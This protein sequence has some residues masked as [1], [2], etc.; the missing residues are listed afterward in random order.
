MSGGSRAATSEVRVLKASLLLF[1]LVGVALTGS[2]L[3]YFSRSEFMPYHSQAIQ[4]DWSALTPHYQGLLIGLL[5]GLAA[6]LIVCGIATVLMAV[7]SLRGSARPY[8]ILLP[9]VCLGYCTL[10]TYATYVVYSRT[11]GEPPLGSGV[12]VVLIALLASAMLE[13]GIRRAAA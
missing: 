8:R 3:V 12:L 11:P 4:T 5:K 6:G 9:V 7:I 2:G 1:L 10:V 13:G